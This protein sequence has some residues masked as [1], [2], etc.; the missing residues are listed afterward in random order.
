MTVA[1]LATTIPS[2]AIAG[3][4]TVQGCHETSYRNGTIVVVAR[5]AGCF[6]GREPNGD[7]NF[8]QW[9]NG[10]ATTGLAVWKKRPDGKCFTLAEDP[11]W[12]I[13]VD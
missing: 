1:I 2:T 10:T 5:Y 7:V 12:S 13:C 6:V 3:G 4:P 11:N 9:Q 8:I